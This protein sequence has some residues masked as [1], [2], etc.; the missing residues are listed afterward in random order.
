MHNI[1]NNDK[2][3]QTKQEKKDVKLFEESF[4]KL[5]LFQNSKC[6]CCANSNCGHDDGPMLYGPDWTVPLY[7]NPELKC[8][9]R[10]RALITVK[11]KEKSYYAQY[12]WK[13]KWT[14]KWKH[15]EINKYILKSIKNQI[16]CNKIDINFITSISLEQSIQSGNIECTCL[17]TRIET[18]N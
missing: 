12:I 18:I 3:E 13:G 17:P 14:G 10:V 2:H 7:T 4:T 6:H 11:N 9:K 5:D 1:N 16:I 15:S 8:D